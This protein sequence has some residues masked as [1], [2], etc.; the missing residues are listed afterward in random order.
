MKNFVP[1]IS[2]VNPWTNEK[3]FVAGLPFNSVLITS[4]SHRQRLPIYSAFGHPKKLFLPDGDRFSMAVCGSYVGVFHPRISQQLEADYKMNFNYFP[5][6]A[7]IFAIFRHPRNE[8]RALVFR[9]RQNA[10]GVLWTCDCR[11][12]EMLMFFSA[13]GSD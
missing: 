8:L 7:S 9:R 6:T 13:Y 2:S 4:S 11:Q 1:A 5:I 12:L 10:G 3:T